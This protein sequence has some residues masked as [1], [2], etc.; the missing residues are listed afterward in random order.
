MINE[1]S[2]N[3]LKS[4][5]RQYGLTAQ[6]NESI[7]RWYLII[8]T[9]IGSFFVIENYQAENGTH[10]LA[11]TR[12]NEYIKLPNDGLTKALFDVFDTVGVHES[13]PTKQDFTLLK[14]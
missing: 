10:L 12:S 3:V 8:P 5:M 9:L 11:S 14:L 4:L 2:S 6:F 13:A 7:N 1:P